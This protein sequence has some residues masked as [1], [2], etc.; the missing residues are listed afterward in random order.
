[1]GKWM[2]LGVKM[3]PTSFFLMLRLSKCRSR[4]SKVVWERDGGLEEEGDEGEVGVCGKGDRRLGGGVCLGFG[5]E[6]FWRHGFLGAEKL[7]ES[8]CLFLEKV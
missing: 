2:E 8:E 6:G 7:Q 5:V 4:R 1:M 3:R